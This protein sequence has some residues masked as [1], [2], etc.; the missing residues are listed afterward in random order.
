MN[1]KLSDEMSRY[2]RDKVQSGQFQDESQVIIAAL[3]GMRDDDE[4]TPEYEA[5]VRSAIAEAEESVR[6]GR[7]GPLDMDAI[8]AEER[9]KLPSR[10]RA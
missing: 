8:I 10:K 3:E 7:V 9:A 1:I 2:V 4:W 6:Q 5:Y